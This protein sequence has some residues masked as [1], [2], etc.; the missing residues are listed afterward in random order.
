MTSRVQTQRFLTAGLRP[1][2]G[3]RPPGELWTNLIE[4]RLGAIDPNQNSIDLLPIRIYTPNAPY[5]QNDLV[6]NAGQLLQAKAAIAAKPFATTDWN[7]YQSMPQTDARYLQ[8]AGGTMTGPL[9][10]SGNPTAAAQASNKAYV[11]ST[12]AAGDAVV[13]AYVDTSVAKYVPLAG[14]TMTGP[15]GVGGNGV[16]FPTLGWT[17]ATAIGW[18]GANFQAAG[19]GTY[20]GALALQ[21]WVNAN[22]LPLSGGTVAHLSV[23]A[24]ITY[25]WTGS[26]AH[27]VSFGW[28]GQLEC[29]VDGTYIGTLATNYQLGGYLPLSGGTVSGTLYASSGRILSYNSGGLPSFTCWDTANGVAGGMWMDAKGDVVIGG[30]DGNGVP[31][32][33][34]A[35]FNPGGTLY[36][37]GDLGCGNYGGNPQISLLAGNTSVGVSFFDWVLARGSDGTLAW[38]PPGRGALFWCDAGGSFAAYQFLSYSDARTKT[39]IALTDCG[40]E[41]VLQLVPVTFR[42]LDSDVTEMGFVAQDVALVIPEAVHPMR[43]RDTDDEMLGLSLNPIVAALVNAAKVFDMRLRNLETAH[44]TA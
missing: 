4:R 3:T 13:H 1:G 23:N 38:Y 6:V 32:V 44:G 8:L 9:N 7:A 34:Y 10:L 27:A 40:L 30:I 41:Q 37:A 12:T 43:A 11:D 19:D 2:N 15:L 14:G 22:F 25:A 39:A 33:P 24:G 29:W 18:D 5:A 42:R 28:D 35:A 21:S 16:T 17:H 20:R 36:L 26:Y 31:S